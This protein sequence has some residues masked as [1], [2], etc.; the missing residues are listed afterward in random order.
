MQQKVLKGQGAIVGL[1]E[2]L[3]SL[4]PSKIFLV[5]GG[6]SFSESGARAAIESILTGYEY[7]RYSGFG[8]NPKLE[9]I[10]K[11]LKKLKA[12]NY[13]LIIGI[14]GG[15]VIDIAKAISVLRYN[16]HNLLDY[17][18]NKR[19]LI[20]SKIPTIIIPTTAGTGSESTHFS[21]VYIDKTK[22][23]FSGKTLYPDFVVLDHSYTR[24]LSPVITANTGMDAFC[25]GVESFW[26]VNSTDESRGYSIKAIK[27]SLS[28][29][30]KAVNNPDDESRKMMLEAANFSGKAINIAQTTAAHAVSYPLTSFFGIPHGHAVA[31]TLPSFLE[32][33]FSVDHDSIQDPR[34]LLFV[35]KRMA[36]LL[37]YIDAKSVLEAKGKILTLMNKIGLKT[38]LSS[39]G[40]TSEDI[41]MLIQNA[42]N[43]QRVVNN[44][45][46]LTES[47]L[48]KI[49]A[50][51]L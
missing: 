28:S 2:V 43:P 33:N 34:G 30:E 47:Q 16:D 15:T 13:D 8:C 14:G 29:I 12:S 45:R 38:S 35:R 24:K 10:E 37:N 9:D 50:N 4:R 23:S 25:Q 1:S 49:L 46:C 31:L 51:I 7:Y 41:R 11:G 42:F 21:V 39:L 19:K 20:K 36:E 32:F 48:L 3:K 22:Y 40:V 44:P 26:S 18:T 6:K 27:L 5:T 17:I